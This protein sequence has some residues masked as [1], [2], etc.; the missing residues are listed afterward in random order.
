MSF[1]Q[2]A[3]AWGS[4]SKTATFLPSRSAATARETARVVLEHPPFWL[5]I[6][7]TFIQPHPYQFTGA[8]NYAWIVIWVNDPMATKL[9]RMGL[10]S[11]GE[12]IN[13]LPYEY[14]ILWMYERMNVWTSSS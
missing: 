14:I 12:R 2:D 8:G 6:P 11:A 7:N 1:Q 5:I 9:H 3:E 4:R 13:R 10:S